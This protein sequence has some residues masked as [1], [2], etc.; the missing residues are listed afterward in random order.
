MKTLVIL[1][2]AALN[3]PWLCPANTQ[4]VIPGPPGSGLFGEDVVKLPNG[5]FLVIDTGFDQ[6]SPPVADVGAVYLYSPEGGLI[7]TLVG[8]QTSDHIG[9][10][11]VRVLANGHFVVSSLFWDNGAVS[12]AGAVTWGHAQ[13]GFGVGQVVAVSAANSLVGS[14]ADDKVGSLGVIALSNGNYV[15]RSPSWNNGAV[16]GAG[17]A[18]W[19]KG[20]TGI[21]GPVT[22]AN[23]LVG[24][25]TDDLVG[26]DAIAYPLDGVNALSDGNYVV[27][28]MFWDN[29]A[30]VNSGAITWGDGGSGSTGEVNP[31]NSVL[32]AVAGSGPSLVFAYD[33][34]RRQL[35]VGDPVANQVTLFFSRDSLYSLAKAGRDAPGALDIAFAVP[36][37]LAVGPDGGA[38]YDTALAGS[39]ARTGRRGLFAPDAGGWLELVLRQGDSVSGFGVGLPANARAGALFG[40]VRQQAGLGL[41]QATV[42]G[43]GVNARNNR[44][45]LLDEPGGVRLLLRGG[46]PIA[47]LGDASV[48]RPLEVVQSHDRNLITVVYALNRSFAPVVVNGGNDSGLLLLRHDG[49]VLANVAARE[50]E[51]A[52]GGGGTFGQLTGRVA[53][54]QGD[55]VHFGALFRPVAGRPLPAVFSTTIDGVTTART[56][57]VGAA[58][59]GAG[60][61]TFGSLRGLSQLG[62]DALFTAT[63][64]GSPGNA[65]EGLWRG[66]GSAV[67]TRKG[68]EVDAVNLPGIRFTRLLR[69]WPA[70]GDQ[71]ILQVQLSD[72]S[73]ALVLR[74]TPSN[75]YLVLLRT[76]QP[77][78]GV[79]PARL[80]TIN[81]V[82][83]NPVTGRYVV[84]GTLAGARAAAN[85]A[86]WSGNP[87]LGND[88]TETIYRLPVLRLRKGQI[89]RTEATPQSIL[90]GISLRPAADRSGAGGR[91]L[92]QAIGSGGQIGLVLIGDRRLLEVVVLK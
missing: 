5:N 15:V 8:T 47:S 30:V 35:V 10:V 39:G 12:N 79:E 54:G 63:L 4:T 48:R 88:T 85:Q 53:A 11:G 6:V 26:W 9:S 7:S 81:A 45:L 71:V 74:Q 60:G 21:S 18:T 49:G 89:Y 62:D 41:F 68:D 90:R 50:G 66:D 65:N 87:S 40:P 34:A 38:L 3:L 58:A 13:T 14:Q 52:F 22:P 32:G 28:S 59:P 51:S 19:G 61:A 86:L 27:N 36:G 43:S 80:R 1:L 29:G 37:A 31:S 84:L 91:G 78:P 82:D 73:Q 70:G 42:T 55:T 24:S 56:A 46:Q 92:A 23:S 67:L 44:L 2:V 72:R 77:A 20:S 17:A 33:P 64:R 83:V 75:T 57:T 69:F 16:G 76:G 25:Q